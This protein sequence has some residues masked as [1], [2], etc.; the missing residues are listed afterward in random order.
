ML[1]ES[2]KGADVTLT[3]ILNTILCGAVVTGVV[4]PLVWAILTQ[5]RHEPT[6]IT[7]ARKTGRAS[8]R[9]AHRSR[10]RWS[11]PIVWPAR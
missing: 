4:A 5:H 6:V 9:V 8:A 2:G 7:T 11:E 3:V 1:S 10:R